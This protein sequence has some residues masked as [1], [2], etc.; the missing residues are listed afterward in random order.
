MLLETEEE[1]QRIYDLFLKDKGAEYPH[2]AD[3]RAEFIGPRKKKGLLRGG[4]EPRELSIHAPKIK[5]GKNW[6]TL[7]PGI[8]FDRAWAKLENLAHHTATENFQSRDAILK[9]F[10]YHLYHEEF[11]D[12]AS[13]LVG[14]CPVELRNKDYKEK[15][16]KPDGTEGIKFYT[17]PICIKDKVTGKDILLQVSFTSWVGDHPS[18]LVKKGEEAVRKLKRTYFDKRR[19]LSGGK[20]YFVTEL[21]R[22]FDSILGTPIELNFV[23]DHI[24]RMDQP[25]LYNSYTLTTPE[26]Y[27]PKAKFVAALE[28]FLR[29]LNNKHGISQGK[30]FGKTRWS[31]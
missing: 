5:Y 1:L 18:T 25:E 22:A 9:H 27:R 10:N 11:F 15:V 26:A 14:L 24:L 16:E 29:D 28:Q 13:G 30:F 19:E 6:A 23:D 4:A 8:T 3:W 21:D 17:I 20:E 2:V 12:P 31:S 7:R